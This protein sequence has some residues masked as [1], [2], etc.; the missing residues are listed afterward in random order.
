VRTSLAALL[1]VVL[2]ASGCASVVDGSGSGSGAPSASSSAE[3]ATPTPSPTSTTPAAPATSSGVLHVPAES[4][5]VKKTDTATGI[6]FDL[7]GVA[8][9]QTQQLKVGDGTPFISREYEVEIGGESGVA[10]SVAMLKGTSTPIVW[11]PSQYA[12]GLVTQFKAQGAPD[13]AISE[14][15][16]STIGGNLVLDFRLGFT[17]TTG[18]KAVWL[19]R[20]IRDNHTL[21]LAQTI[22]FADDPNTLLPVARKL[23]ARLLSGIVVP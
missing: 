3:A 10:L 19:I 23:H 16:Q 21:I 14:Q 2:L 8:K 6:S 15:H 17:A 4:A 12:K 18:T 1:A 7:P 20:L 22:G 11:N 5:W 9:L 13:A